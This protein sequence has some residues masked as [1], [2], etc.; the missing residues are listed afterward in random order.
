MSV[1][2][3]FDVFYY[4]DIFVNELASYRFW[5]KFDYLRNTECY[6]Y[7]HTYGKVDRLDRKIVIVSKDQLYILVCRGSARLLSVCFTAPEF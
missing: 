5:D 4:I 7:I 6:A 2:L 3:K 1:P